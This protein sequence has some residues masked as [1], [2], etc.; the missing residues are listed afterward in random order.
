M[1]ARK[2]I[3]AD[4]EAASILPEEVASSEPRVSG[5]WWFAARAEAG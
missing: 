2:K 1:R 5:G 4:G 3:E